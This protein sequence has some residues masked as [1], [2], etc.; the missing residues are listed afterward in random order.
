MIMYEC[1]PAAKFDDANLPDDVCDVI[2]AQLTLC[3]SNIA[4]A[5]AVGGDDVR[6]S[7][8]NAKEKMC[9]NMNRSWNTLKR[10]VTL[11]VVILPSIII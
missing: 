11:S 7:F 1:D 5:W 4:T 10:L 8:N 6:I 9:V 3:A 2:S